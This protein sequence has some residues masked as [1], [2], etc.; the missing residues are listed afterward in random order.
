MKEGNFDFLFILE[1]DRVEW[2]AEVDDG[3][4]V[5]S[6]ELRVGLQKGFELIGHFFQCVDGCDVRKRGAK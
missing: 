5:D 4:F 6:V 1:F 2:Q 3:V